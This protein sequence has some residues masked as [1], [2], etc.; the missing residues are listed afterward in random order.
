[1]VV[2]IMSL[3]TFT[4]FGGIS[5]SLLFWMCA[6]TRFGYCAWYFSFCMRDMY[7]WFIHG[8]I[9]GILT[10]IGFYHTPDMTW[11]YYILY[12]SQ[13]FAILNWI[14]NK[15]RYDS[16]LFVYIYLI[17]QQLTTFL[18]A[19][20]GMIIHLIMRYLF[21]SITYDETKFV[22]CIGFIVINMALISFNHL[23]QTYPK[24]V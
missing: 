21:G 14:F 13:I 20:M 9:I 6:K 16:D 8:V 23:I 1:M 3:F 11:L 19:I 17:E 12:C 24:Y 4:V 5:V 22:S 10:W 18:G 15:P 7:Y 2:D